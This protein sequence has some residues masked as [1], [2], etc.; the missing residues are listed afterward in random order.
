MRALTNNPPLFL[1][2]SGATM[3]PRPQPVR[4]T[5]ERTPARRLA[6]CQPLCC[7]L[8]PIP[9]PPM[10]APFTT[11]LSFGH[12]SPSCLTLSLP[13]GLKAPGPSSRQNARF[14]W[15]P[16]SLHAYPYP[17][18]PLPTFPIHNRTPPP[19][20]PLLFALLSWHRLLGGPWSFLERPPLPLPCRF[21]LD[22]H[23]GLTHGARPHIWLHLSNTMLPWTC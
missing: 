22:K 15:S 6:A 21:Q 9:P 11:L 7:L 8:P 4:R 17:I 3:A 2:S 16:T 13:F 5:P 19:P 14:P 10:C 20:L 18:L 1:W 23:G 12:L